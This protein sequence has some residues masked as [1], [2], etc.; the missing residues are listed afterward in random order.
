MSGNH[1]QTKRFE[2][3]RIHLAVAIHGAGAVDGMIAA[4]FIT[5]NNTAAFALI[6]LVIEQYDPAVGTAGNDFDFRIKLFLFPARGGQLPEHGVVNPVAAGLVRRS[7]QRAERIAGA[8]EIP[9]DHRPGPVGG[10]VVDDHDAIDEFGHGLDDHAD[11]SFL[12]VGRNHHADTFAVKHN[13]IT[14]I[15]MP[16]CR[17]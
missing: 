5:R 14:P 17:R 4:P 8:V 3:R 1:R 13:R 16:G 7:R 10:G 12:V 6:G 2:F 15:L 9:F 11:L